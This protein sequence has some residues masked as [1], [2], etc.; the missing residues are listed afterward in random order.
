MDNLHELIHESD[1]YCKC[2]SGYEG[3]LC[4]RVSGGAMPANDPTSQSSQNLSSPTG[5]ISGIVVGVVLAASAV[6]IVATVFIRRRHHK[7][8]SS[9]K[10]TEKSETASS[11]PEDKNL[12]SVA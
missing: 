9:F 7:T 1:A 10:S 12:P 4:D 5:P 6:A 2:P 11:G 3:G 8:N